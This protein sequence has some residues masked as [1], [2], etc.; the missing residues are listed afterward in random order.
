MTPCTTVV[1]SIALVSLTATAHLM[2]WVVVPRILKKAEP[3]VS[4]SP[5]AYKRSMSSTDGPRTF[6]LSV[7]PN[8]EG[9]VVMRATLHDHGTRGSNVAIVTVAKGEVDFAAFAQVALEQGRAAAV[10]SCWP[11]FSS[12]ED[13]EP[14][15]PLLVELA[16][17]ALSIAD[18][19]EKH[20]RQWVGDTYLYAH[21][22]SAATIFAAAVLPRGVESRFES[23]GIIGGVLVMALIDWLRMRKGKS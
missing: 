22:V 8:A 12:L 5:K 14:L 15:R 7:A 10:A 16:E 6:I 21:T 4:A 17:A 23:G 9:K 3:P 11:A 20:R 1:A 19:G 13:P 18:G 2:R